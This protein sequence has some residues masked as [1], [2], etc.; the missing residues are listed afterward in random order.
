MAALAPAAIKAALAGEAEPSSKPKPDDDDTD[1]V[2][3]AGRRLMKRRGWTR[4][5][6]DD[7][8]AMLEGAQE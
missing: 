1:P 7:L 6:L 8:M 2:S 3:A 5:D 4:E